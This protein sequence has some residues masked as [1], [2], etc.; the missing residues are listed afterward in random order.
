[1]AKIV[2]H[3]SRHGV[4]TRRYSIADKE[5]RPKI[6][7][8]TVEFS[9]EQVTRE[10]V[11]I[12]NSFQVD[13]IG[14]NVAKLHHPVRSHLALSIQEPAFAVLGLDYWVDHKTGDADARHTSSH[15]RKST[16]RIKPGGKFR[17]EGDGNAVSN[18]AA[19]SHTRL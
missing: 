14:A 4:V 2:A 1:M 15:T 6:R 7:V 9:V 16:M 17:I 13:A 19:D 8:D 11:H 18:M 3:F 10:T 12:L 5:Q